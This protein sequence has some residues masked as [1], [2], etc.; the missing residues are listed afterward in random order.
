[1]SLPSPG[2]QNEAG[3]GIS[4]SG[5]SVV[6]G[7]ARPPAL[8]SLSLPLSNQCRSEGFSA[9]R[10]AAVAAV[11]FANTT[12]AHDDECGT[13]MRL[14]IIAFVCSPLLYS[15]PREA[16]DEGVVAARRGDEVLRDSCFVHKGRG[17]R[18][19]RG[20]ALLFFLRILAMRADILALRSVSGAGGKAPTPILSVCV[21]HSMYLSVGGR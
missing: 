2:G 20:K 18:E 4:V 6:R 13:I 15:S 7:D 10:T 19:E 16:S 11:T 21:R 5:R 3:A 17:P 12:T 14:L 1:M 9:N 8:R